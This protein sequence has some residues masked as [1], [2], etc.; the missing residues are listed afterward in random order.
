[1]KTLL[2]FAVVWGASI[3]NSFWEAYVEGR[4]TM[5]LGKLGWKIKI[6]KYYF[7][8]YHFYLFYVMWPLLISLPLIV[9]GWDK[10]LFGILLSAFITGNILEDFM[11]FVVN[12]VVKLSEFWSSF[13]DHYAWIK[14]GKIKII[15]LFYV[16]GIMLASL[17][18]YFLWR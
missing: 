8:G 1:M 4:K 10:R 14:L 13:T 12:P 11:W 17:S 3:A 9:N 7:T 2:I 16:V 6:G 15:P 18:W 5:E